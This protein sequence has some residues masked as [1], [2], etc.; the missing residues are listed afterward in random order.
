MK[1]LDDQKFP[2]HVYRIDFKVAPQELGCNGIEEYWVE[3][4]GTI[5]EEPLE[6]GQAGKDIGLIQARLF[7]GNDALNDDVDAY[8][9][10][11][12]VSSSVE[13]LFWAVHNSDG[14]IAEA[15]LQAL[16]EYIGFNVLLI[17]LVGLEFEY[18][19]RGLAQ[20]ALK[21]LVQTF[22]NSAI[23]AL[24]NSPVLFAKG[25]AQRACVPSTE[26]QIQGRRKMWRAMGFVPSP[27]VPPEQDLWIAD[28]GRLSAL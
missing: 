12:P 20:A 25:K 3:I 8:E 1:L 14:H 27:I 16:P 13:M 26:E 2:D 4:V 11:E 23:I 6:E 9:C 10:F 17:E 24:Q 19:K 21:R 15:V 22:G 28:G 7:R 18:R 5:R